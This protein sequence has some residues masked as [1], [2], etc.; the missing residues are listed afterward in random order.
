MHDMV[1]RPVSTAEQVATENRRGS[2]QLIVDATVDRRP[3]PALNE[4]QRLGP[5]L[6]AIRH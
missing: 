4:A 2:R 5:L 1:G 6:R 3:Y